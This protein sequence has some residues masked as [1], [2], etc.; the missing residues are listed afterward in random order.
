MS[1]QKTVS[2][3]HHRHGVP[4]LLST[5]LGKFAD[6]VVAVWSLSVAGTFIGLI[7][8]MGIVGRL[9]INMPE[10]HTHCPCPPAVPP[11]S[12]VLWTD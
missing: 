12:C 4:D 10:T 11:S 9:V 1:H 5:D 8:G 3:S 2:Y 7:A 6:V